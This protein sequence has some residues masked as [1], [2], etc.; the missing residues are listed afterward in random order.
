MSFSSDVKKEL[1]RNI[2][3]ARHCRIAE[4]AGMIGMVGHVDCQDGKPVRIVISTERSVIA[5]TMSELIKKLFG[6][7]PECSVKRT[8]ADSRVYKMVFNRQEDVERILTTLK[9]TEKTEN[10]SGNVRGMDCQEM[11]ISGLVIQKDCCR[12]AFIKGVFMTS[13]SISDPEKGYHFEIVCDNPERAE[14]ISGIIHNFDIDSK[15]IARKR[16]HVVYIKDGTMIVDMLNLMGAYSSLM[17]ME[18]IRI[19]KDI[20]NNVNRKVNCEAANLNKTVNAAVR[21]IEDI[22]YIIKVK[23]IHYLPDNLVELAQARLEAR[24]A[25]LKELGEMI[26][27]PIGKSGVNHRL[28]KI[29]EIADHLRGC[30]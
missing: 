30:R 5:N 1:A 23:G 11:H 16:Y 21:Q 20:A 10:S 7:V 24:D 19:L 8:G 25:S 15:V 6:L 27:P 3:A 18:N 9:I 12:R 13:G 4:L 28:R 22:E 29:S 14:L 17:D 2:S 26:N